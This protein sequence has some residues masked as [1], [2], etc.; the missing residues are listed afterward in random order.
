MPLATIATERLILRP[1]RRE[2]AEAIYQ[3]YA[4]DPEVARYVIWKPH[5]SIEETVAFLDHFLEHAEGDGYPWIMTLPGGEIIGAVHL[6]VRVPWSEFGFNIAKRHWGR[7]YGTEAVRGV[8]GFGLALP[9][10]YRVQAVCH[11]ENGASARVMEKAGMV[12][13]GTLRRYMLFPNL[14]SEPQDVFMY[15]TTR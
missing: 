4:T 14:G 6:R 11:V 12:R 8:I 2:D 1:P 15:A 10:I 3:A 7:G 5:R 13:E 9:A